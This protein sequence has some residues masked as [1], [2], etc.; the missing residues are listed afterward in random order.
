MEKIEKEILNMEK[1]RAELLFRL[2]HTLSEYL[3]DF[4]SSASVVGMIS[5]Y[6]A[7]GIAADPSAT[8]LRWVIA[9]L[10]LIPT[11]YF[12]GP[13]IYGIRKWIRITKTSFA[14]VEDTLCGTDTVT[15]SSSGG[16]HIPW[17]RGATGKTLYY[18][19]KFRFAGHGTYTTSV[20]HFTW[21]HSSFRMGPEVLKNV[22]QTGDKFYLILDERVKE[23]QAP[24]ILLAYPCKFFQW[25]DR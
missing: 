18:R 15:S 11:P 5:F 1:C 3:F 24:K 9:A 21:K 19:W 13:A 4:I 17:K 12:V 6:L 7:I 8:N 16:F 20:T 10:W 14:V 23:G 22:S 25:E 2:K